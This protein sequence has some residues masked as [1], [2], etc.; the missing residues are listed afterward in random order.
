MK[1]CSLYIVFELL[2]RSNL[3]LTISA[4]IKASPIIDYLIIGAGL[5]GSSLA[6]RMEA[7]EYNYK[8]FDAPNLASASQVAAGVI[9]PVTGK[10]MTESWKI[11]TLMPKAKAFYRDIERQLGISIYHDLPIRRYFIN[12]A[13]TLRARR[14][15]KNPRYT[16]YFNPIIE[17]KAEPIGI[18]DKFGS[19]PIRQGSWVNVP[20]LIDHLKNFFQ[21]QNRFVEEAFDMKQ[22][23][24][25]GSHWNYRGIRAKNI[26][27]CQGSYT[28]NNPFF[29]DLPIIPIKGDVLDISLKDI[30]L[31][32]GLY[33]KK[34]WLHSF[35]NED[36]CL[37]YR[38]GASYDLG[39]SD[40]EPSLSAKEE[41]IETLKAM[42]GSNLQFTIQAHRSGIRPTTEDAKP[43]LIRH[44]MYSSL[45]A[46]NGLG[47]KG[48]AMAPYLSELFIDQI[49][50]TI[51]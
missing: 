17:K 34:R 22:L 9:N 46:I 21:S 37:L 3:I 41:L 6:W 48:S 15:I 47:S 40:A 13:D 25:D 20:C 19:I 8:I 44:P 23:E 31:P 7:S 24:L 42:L 39:N 35:A 30:Q 16:N 10:W 12:K 29:K 11:D 5:A 26:V 18:I 51:P 38:L 2:V 27:F 43:L 49:K 45:F 50:K 14:R 32:P 1:F 33:Y 28:H 4:T 36:Q